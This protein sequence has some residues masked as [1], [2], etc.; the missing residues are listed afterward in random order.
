MILKNGI[1]LTDNFKFNKTDIEIKGLQ[2]TGIGDMNA[3]TDFLDLTNMYVLPG[4]ID[5]H[6]HGAYGVRFSDPVPDINKITR[7][8]ATRG[9]T[10]IAATTSSSEFSDLL[11][12]FDCIVA[13]MEKGTDGA[14]IAGIHAEGPF[15]NCKFKGAMTEK[16]IITPTAEKIEQLYSHGKGNLKI[17]SIAPEIENA[18]EA[19]KY[20]VTRGIVV[21]MGHTNATFDEAKNGV[22]C[23]ATQSTHT[24]NAMRPYNHRELGV[25]G[26]VLTNPKVKCEMICDFVHL[27][28]TTIK[29]IYNIKGVDQINMISDSG[30]SAGIELTKF[31][32]DG[33]M[34]YVKDGVVRLADGTIA[35]STKTL[36]EGV[37]NLASIGIPLED[38]SKMI[39][40]NPAKSIGIDNQTGTITKGKQAD[41]VVLNKE[42]EVVYT[43]VD[44]MIAYKKKK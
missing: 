39:S 36:L 5:T 34:R 30:H 24:F 42:L 21:S 32:V 29:L 10:T 26:C 11:R 35:G 20:F 22:C 28:P 6:M 25:L 14:K 38:I 37:Q 43:F 9:V 31:M 40:L 23:G 13:A 18:D 2:I 44:G 16:N 27:H 33:I 3:D 7:F 1:V 19:I 41:L 8:E 17:I 4:F 12:Q 15:L